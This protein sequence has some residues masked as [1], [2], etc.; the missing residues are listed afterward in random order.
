MLGRT[1]VPGAMRKGKIV[2]EAMDTSSPL[3][4]VTSAGPT[5]LDQS[6]KSAFAGK[7]AGKYKGVAA[8]ISGS[9]EVKVDVD[10]ND[11]VIHEIGLGAHQ[12]AWFLWRCIGAKQATIK[13]QTSSEVAANVEV[14]QLK[15]ALGSV[16]AS[17]TS[18]TS[19]GRTFK[20]ENPDLCIEGMVAK[21]SGKFSD[22]YFVDF[23][24]SGDGTA[25]NPLLA[26]LCK[27]ESSGRAW[28]EFHIGTRPAYVPKTFISL[29]ISEKGPEV[30]IH[31][32]NSEPKRLKPNVGNS[33]RYSNVP[34]ASFA[35]GAKTRK[36]ILVSFDAKLDSAGC[37][38][39]AQAQMN[40]PAYRVRV[41]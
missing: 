26:R 21:A 17:M 6:D 1:I 37:V 32:D 24:Q 16:S 33:W 5:E 9:R 34:V 30:V 35:Y 3:N 10:A 38:E 40:Y 11:V 28:P 39:F 8:G 36:V 41:W 20:V 29:Q 15:N 12:G 7:L 13:I 25:Q 31:V 4:I 14:E 27:D 23:P 2:F 19:S 18:E 22:S